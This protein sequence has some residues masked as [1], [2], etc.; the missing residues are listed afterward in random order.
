M[1]IYW[2]NGSLKLSPESDAEFDALDLLFQGSKSA[3]PPEFISEEPHGGSVTN[4]Q[5]VPSGGPVEP[6]NEDA[7][8]GVET[9]T[10]SNLIA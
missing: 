6:G 8:V 9:A 7:V 2:H 5:V 4:E 3:K 10:T 1:Y